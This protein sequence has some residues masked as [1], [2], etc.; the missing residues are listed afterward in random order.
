MKHNTISFSGMSEMRK[1]YKN[2]KMNLSENITMFDIT[3]KE[4]YYYL[5]HNN[6]YREGTTEQEIKDGVT[7]YPFMDLYEKIKN[8]VYEE[9]PH[10]IKNKIKKK[11]LLF[12]DRGLGVFSFDR[13]AMGLKRVPVF[14]SKKH[15]RNVPYNEV[16]QNGNKFIYT[17]DN[18]PL[19]KSEKISSS[20][21][22]VFAYFPEIDKNEKA[23]DIYF[24]GE[25]PSKA[26]PEQMIYCGIPAII[27]AEMLIK[28]GYKVRISAIFGSKTR[29]KT[30]TLSAIVP[31]KDFNRPIDVNQLLIIAS[32]ATFNRTEGFLISVHLFDYFNLTCPDDLGIP[33]KPREMYDITNELNIFNNK[34]IVTGSIFSKEDVIENISNMITYLKS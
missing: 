4:L 31:V 24:S 20:N 5:R 18:S 30:K 32:D 2:R 29:D 16:Q 8:E 34:T 1:W 23:I 22:K 11:K 12:N 17:K 14:Y 13:A 15:N 10:D 9:I 26:T 7:V 19:K 28:A 21:K 3:E 33:I 6:W 25:A 27:I